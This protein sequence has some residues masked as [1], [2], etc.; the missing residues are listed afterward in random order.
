MKIRLNLLKPFSDAV[1]T[2]ELDIDYPGGDI[3]ALCAFLV[4]KY[5]R[6]KEELYNKD[7]SITNYLSIFL[8]DKPVITDDG[9][10]TEL[11]DGDE[12]L[13]LAPISGG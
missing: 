4:E 9:M 1:G 3:I 5:P 10:R 6:L 12:L 11:K 8:N 2:K 13:F 7:G